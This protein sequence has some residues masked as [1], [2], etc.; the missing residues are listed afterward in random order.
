MRALL[1]PQTTPGKWSVGLAVAFGILVWMKIQ[2]V[3]PVPSFA[4]FAPGLAAFG[5]AAFAVVR[6]RDASILGLLPILA[7]ALVMF[8]T[9]TMF[10]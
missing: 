5:L 7:G 9:T 2:D 3:M 1:L 4:I 8:W 10:M 6:R